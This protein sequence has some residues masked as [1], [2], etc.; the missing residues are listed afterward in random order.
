VDTTNLCNLKCS[1]CG[2]RIMKRK[3]GIMDPA[4]CHKII[5]EIA[6]EDKSVRLWMVFFGEAL[7]LKERLYPLIMYAKDKGLEDVVL[8]S[9][10]NLLDATA[11]KRL[12]ESGLDGIYV[13]I[14]AISP[15][16]YRRLR[17]QGNYERV[18]DNVNGLIEMKKQ[19]RVSHP[20]VYVQFVEMAENIHEL[21]PFKEYWTS[22]GAI[23][24]I[25]P[26]VSWAGVVEAPNL[27]NRQRYPCYWAMRTLNVCWDG[28]VVLC[29]V[30]FDANL[31]AGDL[32]YE[33]V[34]QAWHGPLREIRMLHSSDRF[35][36]LPDFCRLCKDWQAARA[37][38]YST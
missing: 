10:G 17:V 24:K 23:V 4:L 12:I 34:K 3:K 9:N 37:D 27:G 13:G 16:T 30:D 7:I 36:K 8:N 18:V 25:R 31:V 29:S 20:Q 19:K 14:D 22:R 1:M 26:K 28:R 11:A 32:N 5:D 6:E 35:D 21:E 33:T 38:Y 15:K 2:H